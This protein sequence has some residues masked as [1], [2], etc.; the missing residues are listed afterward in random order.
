MSKRKRRR[1]EEQLRDAEILRTLGLTDSPTQQLAQL[2]QAM[3]M[4]DAPQR[5]DA[6]FAQEMGLRQQEFAQ[7]GD[8]GNRELDMRQAEQAM[9]DRQ[10][11]M[12]YAQKDRAMGAESG[13]RNRA[14]GME[15]QKNAAMQQYY[16]DELAERT[17]NRKQG[18]YGNFFTA[19]L[20]KSVLDPASKNALGSL[21]QLLGLGAMFQGGAPSGNGL[22]AGFGDVPSGFNGLDSARIAE[23]LQKLNL[24]Q[25]QQ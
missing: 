2:V 23:Q 6:R 24:L 25:P 14:L 22:P 5:E 4:L 13:Y 7:R 18:L 21:A 15:G 20:Q 19:L 12:D 16:R 8:M 10:F 1:Q 11:G 9:R 17:A 3:N